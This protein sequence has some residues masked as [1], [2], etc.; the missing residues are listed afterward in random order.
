M[1]I[2]DAIRTLILLR[3]PIRQPEQSAE[4]ILDFAN[5]NQQEN[6]ETILTPPLSDKEEEKV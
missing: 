6:S 5:N 1:K 4:M 3:K 2:S